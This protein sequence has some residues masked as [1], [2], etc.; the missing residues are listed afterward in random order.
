MMAGLPILSMLDGEGAKLVYD[1]NC[2]LGC[3]SGDYRGLAQNI[4]KL[5]HMDGD[6]LSKLGINGRTYAQKHFSK[7]NLVCQLEIYMKELIIEG[8]K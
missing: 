8:N 4:I 1:A 6:K 2:G 3:P 7:D 5:V